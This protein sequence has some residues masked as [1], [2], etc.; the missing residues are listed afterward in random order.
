M[1]DKWG[2]AYVACRL[3]EK[4]IRVIV[5]DHELCP[6]VTLEEVVV[7]INK[8]FSWIS[9]YVK[10]NSIKSVSFAG[11]SAGGHLLACGLNK[12][13]VN[14]ITT[15]VKLFAYAI[16]GIYDLQELRH[17]DAANQ[18]NILSLDDENVSLLSPQFHDFSHL[19]SRN[20]KFYVFAG[21]YESEKFKQQ[22]KDFAEIPLKK[23]NSVNFEVINGLDHFDI[24]EKLVDEDYLLTKLIVE[25]SKS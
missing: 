22:S 23:L 11:H 16:S 20:I 24:V 6:K 17:L 12:K 25:N 1:C 8:S 9:N 18:N 5:V 3:V 4:G 10:E 21:E 15:D 13:F 19:V 7:Q 14:S 2:S